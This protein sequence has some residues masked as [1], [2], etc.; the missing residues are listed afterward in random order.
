MPFTDWTGLSGLALAWLLLAVR[1]PFVQRLDPMR[2]V[3][4]VVVVYALLLLPV[5]GLSLAGWLR[6]MVGDL[7]LTSVLLLAGALYGRLHPAAVPLWDARERYALLLFLSG[8]ALLLYPFALGWG[9]L[10]PYRSGYG[11]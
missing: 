8:M 6:G 5:S 1:L 7:S 2:R 11:S 10:D 3:L 9:P 4:F